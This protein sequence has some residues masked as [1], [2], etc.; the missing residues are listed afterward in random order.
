MKKSLS[1]SNLLP[2]FGVALT[3]LFSVSMWKFSV[4]FIA[5]EKIPLVVVF[6]AVSSLLFAAMASLAI[7]GS[8]INKKSVIAFIASVAVF[9]GIL[10]SL[11]TIVNVDGNYN[12]RA[13]LVAFCVLFALFAILCLVAFFR[14]KG[15]IV[16]LGRITAVVLFVCSLL[17]GAYIS[18]A[19]YLEIDDKMFIKNSIL[20]D[21]DVSFESLTATELEISQ[22][23]KERCKNWFDE[24]I[25]NAGTNGKTPAYNFSV[26]GVSLHSSLSDWTFTVD[27]E[28]EIYRGG[29]TTEI[30]VQHK[31]SKLLATVE[32][33]IYEDNATCEWTVHIK[34]TDDK[35][36]GV[37]S[38]FCG[39][40]FNLDI[41]SADLYCNKGSDNQSYDFTPMK[42]RS[43][44]GKLTFSGRNG[45]STANYLPYF[46]LTGENYSEVL[47]VGW[48]GQW[49]A[50]INRKNSC[51]D[52]IAKQE[53]FEAYLLPN[54][55]IRSPLISLSFYE[56]ENPVK[57]YNVFRN[58]VK[59][60][61]QPENIPD[62]MT[63]YDILYVSAVRT[64]EE[65][66]TDINNADPMVFEQSDYLWMDAG[67]W[68]G[69]GE[70]WTTGRGNWT[71]NTERFPNGIK[72]LSDKA[73]S[74]GNGLVLWY[75]T[76]NVA[77][78]TILYNEAVKHNGWVVAGS[79]DN[80]TDPNVFIWNFAEKN[81]AEFITEYIGNTL[82][83]NGVSV[84][85]HD[86]NFFPLTYWEDADETL[87]G[88]RTGITENHYVTNLYGYFDKLI[89]M[90]PGL[91]VDN[92]ASGGMRLDL[93]MLRRSVPLW[94]SDYNCDPHDDLTEAT[95]AHTFGLSMWLPFHGTSFYGE[96][97]YTVRS[98]IYPSYTSGLLSEVSEE[99]TKYNPE[100]ENMQKNYYPLIWG[101]TKDLLAMQFGNSSDGSVFVYGRENTKEGEV[102]IKLSGLDENKTYKVYNYDTPEN[103]LSVTGK[104]LMSDGFKLA[105]PD[106]KSA[107][108][109]NYY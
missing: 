108:I 104:E 81:A 93:E 42:A 91:I 39:A 14:N 16:V 17:T 36:S 87:Y 58:W 101:N 74:V 45:K 71:T 13:V 31:N 59:D 56:S 9:H 10:W 26:D 44:L 75:E 78:D 88:G 51:A 23:E 90:K 12:T 95:Q 18:L 7:A 79:E 34:N 107:K 43:G 53:N 92:C 64:A 19:Q 61:V 6:A 82:K 103:I 60:S 28:K 80:H 105:L 22:S 40:D 94:R 89:E 97:E 65:M 99:L 62:T 100:R 106:G 37:I 48:T 66:L 29:K 41:K 24:N 72:E 20:F 5:W 2:L 57:G 15:G 1:V 33:T 11:L 3:A 55:E 8:K 84:Y 52:I 38:D 63:N 4:E 70:T 102:A 96:N 27:D 73:E 76:E 49:K 85:R 98:S 32:A 109:I 50:E 69:I 83:E 67:W 86:F 35:N 46:N 47:G 68:D 54:E 30:S 77:K 21:S 25:I